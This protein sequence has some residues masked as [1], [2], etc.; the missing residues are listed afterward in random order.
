M[1]DLR[2]IFGFAPCA[3]LAY[4]S[5]EAQGNGLVR[6]SQSLWNWLFLVQNSAVPLFPHVTYTSVSLIAS[7]W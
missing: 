5:K 7:G 6:V 1:V 4:S 3:C 2:L